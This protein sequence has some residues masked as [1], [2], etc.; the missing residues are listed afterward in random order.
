MKGQTI[1][2]FT[3]IFDSLT[4]NISRSDATTGIIYDRVCPFAS[5]HAYDGSLQSDTSN[6]DHFLGDTMTMQGMHGSDRNVQ[7]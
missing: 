7:F 4:V 3:E 5:L 6:F 2:T 1:E